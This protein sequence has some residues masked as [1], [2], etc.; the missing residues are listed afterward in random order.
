M[1]TRNDAFSAE[2]LG[3]APQ[4]SSPVH[5]LQRFKHLHGLPLQSFQKVQPLLLI[6]SDHPHLMC[7]VEQVRLG[8]RG[9]PAAVHTHLGWVLQVP[10]ML[11][12]ELLAPS[13]FSFPES[14]RLE[15]RSM[16]VPC[17]SL[18]VGFIVL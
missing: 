2:K 8:P 4:S 1:Q 9:G 7:P 3:L 11:P 12:R 13:D 10:T 15:I 5:V 6:G 14:E 18:E 16:F 17:T